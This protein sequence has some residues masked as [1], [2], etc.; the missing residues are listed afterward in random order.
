MSTAPR[1]ASRAEAHKAHWFS[2]RHQTNE[3]HLDAKEKR[4]IVRGMKG[5][6]IARRLKG[7][8]LDAIRS[9]GVVS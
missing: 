8:T 7:L 3:A 9:L 2:R 1:F 4:V 6:R 5:Q